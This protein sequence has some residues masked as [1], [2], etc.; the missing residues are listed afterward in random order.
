MAIFT[1]QLLT[2]ASGSVGGLTFMRT[3]GGM[4]L[5]ARAIPPNRNSPRQNVIRATLAYLSAYW[6]QTL[7]AK[8]RNAWAT[9]AASIKRPNRLGRLRPISPISTWI[10]AQLPRL[11]AGLRLFPDA[12]TIL[13]RA[14][15]TP[16][17]PIQANVISQTLLFAFDNADAWARQTLGGMLV[18]ITRPQNTSRHAFNRTYRFA[19][20]IPGHPLFP[21]SSPASIRAPFPFHKLQHLFF[22]VSVH[23]RDN[24]YSAAQRSV[25]TTI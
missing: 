2:A 18:Y 6:V 19:G 21:P 17:V 3:T 14:T 22:R 13:T 10:A 23:R 11:N 1:S 8:Q 5:R 15:F 4:A 24:R 12:P 16:I 9:Y 25:V 20:L 7:N